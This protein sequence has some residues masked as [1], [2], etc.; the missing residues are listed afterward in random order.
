MELSACAV[1]ASASAASAPRSAILLAARRCCE[2]N[3]SVI[4]FM[5]SRRA[6]YAFVG[7]RTA[8]ICEIPELKSASLAGSEEITS[9]GVTESSSA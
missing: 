8:F 4:V 3:S 2:L 6:A 1:N 7:V 9:V 5:S